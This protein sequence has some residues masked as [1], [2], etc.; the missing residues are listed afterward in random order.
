[1]DSS[2][3]KRD[4]LIEKV[5]GELPDRPTLGKTLGFEYEELTGERVV[6]RLPITQQ[7]HQPFGIVHGGTYAAMAE[8]VA[9]VGGQAWLGGNGNVVGV[10]NNTDFLRAAREGTLRAVGTPVHQGRTQQL[11]RVEIRDDADRLIA[12]SQVRLAN[13]GDPDRLGKPAQ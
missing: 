9:S 8:E 7:V 1:M 10:N 6:M 5:F 11:W 2:S 3:H 12:T 4:A 13:I